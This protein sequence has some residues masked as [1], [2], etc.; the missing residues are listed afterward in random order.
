MEWD[1]TKLT[2]HIAERCAPLPLRLRGTV[3]LHPAALPDREILLDGKH[4]R[5]SPI[6]P[7]ARVEASFTDPGVSWSGPAYFDTNAGASPLEEAFVRWD[8]SRAPSPTG[9]SVLYN[10]LLNSGEEFCAALRYRLDGTVEDFDP[11]PRVDLPGTLWRL[12]RRT[13]VDPGQTARVR[14]TLTDAPFYARSVIETT[15][16]GE[17]R[18]AMHESLDLRRFTAPWVQAM[19]PFKAPRSTLPTS[20]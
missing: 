16:H 8:W 17:R 15:L 12:P 10:G 20:S 5:W 4:H 19:L 6:A 11:P 2:I 18:H 7:I 3:T 13:R 14:E 1:G 9:T